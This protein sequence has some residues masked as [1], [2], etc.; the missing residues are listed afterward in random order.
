ML[1]GD[2]VPSSLQRS[3]AQQP[4]AGRS[5]YGEAPSTPA[6][7]ISPDGST[8]YVATDHGVWAVD[9]AAPNVRAT[10]L[11]GQRIASAALSRDS[12]RLYALGPDHS[13][14]ALGVARGDVLGNSALSG[15]WAIEQ[16]TSKS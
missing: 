3:I 8:N 9:T 6:P 14:V 2:T 13:L 1:R 12:S 4:G 7:A 16:V 11:V 15:A 10:Y 5:P